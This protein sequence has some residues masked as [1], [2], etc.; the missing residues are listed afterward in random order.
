ME[1]ILAA[2]GLN[3]EAT[4]ADALK[5]IQSL[6]DNL[7]DAEDAL[8]AAAPKANPREALIQRKVAAGLSRESAIEAINNQ[9]AEDKLVE[10]REA[11]A[12]ADKPKN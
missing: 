1:K 9:E 12:K 10:K 8:K 5:A 4:E 2:L 7:T 3:P 6:Q 11:K